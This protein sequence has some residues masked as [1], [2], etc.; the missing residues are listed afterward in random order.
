MILLYRQQ[1]PKYHYR[2]LHSHLQTLPERSLLAIYYRFWQGKTIEEV[3]RTLRVDWN[4][5]DHLINSG[6][7][8]LRDS[9]TNDPAFAPTRMVE[10]LFYGAL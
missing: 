8:Q 1:P 7:S 2:I 9:L 6:L 10:N 3:A 4:R 5:A